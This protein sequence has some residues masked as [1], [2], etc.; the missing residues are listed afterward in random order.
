MCIRDR[1][2]IQLTGDRSFAHS[3]TYHG[4]YVPFA[5]AN[6]TIQVQLP[7]GSL[8][9]PYV[10]ASQQLEQ[11]AITAI[12]EA[13]Q[14]KVSDAN[15][16]LLDAFQAEQ[17]I[18][19]QGS[20]ISH[21]VLSQ[22][23][24]SGA[25]TNRLPTALSDVYLLMPSNIVRIGDI[26]AG[27]TR[28][29]AFSLTASQTTCGTLVKQV[30]NGEAGIITQYDHLFVHS[31]GP[32]LSARQRHLSL[33][34]FM[35]TAAQCNNS[36]FETGGSTATMIGWADQPLAG[37]SAVTVNG[38]HP[39]GLHETAVVA[40]LNLSYAMGFLTLPSDFI[41]GRLVD[42][43]ALGAHLL[44]SDSYAFAHGQITFEYSLPS[45]EYF[46]IQ[47]MALSQPVD[48]SIS[49]G[50]QPGGLHSSSHVALY[51]WQTNS[52]EIIRLT[53]SMPFSTQNAQAYFSSDGRMLVQY[54][55]QASDFSEIAFT[56]PSLT[57]TGVNAFS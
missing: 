3:T 39:S 18:S 42:S 37:E 5:P 31:A 26:A 23:M 11:A 43:E 45:L 9:Q 46:H 8:V 41:S 55:D 16:R 44:S 33:L 15:V 52:W 50:E 57:V 27:Q 49:P 29:V 6:S 12:P 32:S 30:V 34:A 35:L 36:S 17:D 4:V 14:V 47:T 48:P 22:G 19:M 2:I 1:S 54:V 28:S 24:V 38:I 53:Q 13:T 25:V 21:L 7:T 40:A 10:D 51:N 20:I 56:M